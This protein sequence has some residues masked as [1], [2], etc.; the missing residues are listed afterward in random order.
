MLTFDDLTALS[1]D[2]L[3]ALYAGGTVP[4]D[5]ALALDDKPKGRLVAVRGL[6]SVPVVNKVIDIFAR[7]PLFPW[8]GK[9]MEATSEQTADG[10]NRIK[11][12]AKMNWFPFKTRVQPSSIDGEPTIVLDYEQKGN[13]I[14]IKKIHDEIREVA[15][16]MYL[17]PAMAKVGKGK[18]P[19]LV[20]WFALD[21]NK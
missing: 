5:F 10:I 14:L 15:P 11:A 19:V 9:T 2:Q 21:T 17:G 7:H 12:G 13:P 3:A 1:L 18:P 4:D 8:D 6:D 16:G 20:L